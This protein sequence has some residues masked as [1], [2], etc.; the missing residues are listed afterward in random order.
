MSALK[1]MMEDALA[2]L[3]DLKD[4]PA[5]KKVGK[6]LQ[7]AEDECPW[8]GRSW[9]TMLKGGEMCRSATR[10]LALLRSKKG[11]NKDDGEESSKEA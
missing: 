10:S 1:E 5:G 3:K 8:C 4:K 2:P 11:K 7:I 9:C 6:G